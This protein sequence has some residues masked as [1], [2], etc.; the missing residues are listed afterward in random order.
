MKEIAIPVD[1]EVKPHILDKR[2]ELVWAISAQGYSLG[3]IVDMFGSVTSRTRA[4]RIIA[5]KPLEWV[6]KWTKVV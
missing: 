5:L 3:E 6:P 4:Q 1:K 2:N